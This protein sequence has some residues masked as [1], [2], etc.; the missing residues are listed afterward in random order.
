[1]YVFDTVVHTYIHTYVHTYNTTQYTV[2]PY[3]HTDSYNAASPGQHVPNYCTTRNTRKQ[4]QKHSPNTK[5]V[6]YSTTLR[7]EDRTPVLLWMDGHPWRGYVT[8]CMDTYMDAI[9]NLLSW[10][11]R[12]L[13]T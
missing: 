1:M 5:G 2:F 7:T 11:W 4:H 10:H 12:Q 6:A 13:V 9:V 3:K 8:A